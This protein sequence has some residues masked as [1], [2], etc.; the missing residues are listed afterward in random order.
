M[1][2]RRIL[3]AALILSLGA[4]SGSALARTANPPAESSYSTVLYNP[5]TQA[6]LYNDD[7]ELELPIASIT[8]IMTALVVVENCRLNDTLTF[9][10]EWQV[11]GS[12]S[13]FAP[14]TEYTARQMLYALLLTSGNDAAVGLAEFT[15]GSVEAFAD[16]M[17]AKAQELGLTHTHFVN[18]HGLDAN[19]HYSSALDMAKL[20]AAAMNNQKFA[21]VASTKEARVGGI[22]FRN[23]N[24]LLWETP[25]VIGVK[26]GYTAKAGRT[27]VTMAVRD[28]VTLICV[29]L[30]DADDWKDHT[31]LYDWGFS[32]S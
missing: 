22:F 2:I 10:S 3:A 1:K 13:G 15:S 30:K 32:N 16:L 24:K 25:G 11:E 12:S 29:T 4:L 18:P 6:V 7:C 31:A 21:L 17:N 14:G 5:E 28:G 26:T 19:G 20:T 8:K 9:K 23:H 27:L